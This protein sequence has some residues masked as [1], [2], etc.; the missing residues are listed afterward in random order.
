VLFVNVQRSWPLVRAGEKSVDESI[1]GDWTALAEDSLHRHADAIAGVVAGT[2]VAVFDIDGWDRLPGGKV[3]FRGTR[4]AKWAHLEGASS[5]VVWSRG[6]A[7]P[8]RYLDSRQIDPGSAAEPA[9]PDRDRVSLRGWT[10]Q[11]DPDG[12]GVLTIPSGRRVTV[13]TAVGSRSK[14][15]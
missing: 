14:K 7:R 13:V 12:N 10:L 15:T 8:I 1:L 9:T 4:S 3:R 11:V 5:P 6:Q 2:V